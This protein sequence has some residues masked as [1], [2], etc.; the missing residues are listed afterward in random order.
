MVTRRSAF[1]PSAVYSTQV[2]TATVGLSIVP[3]QWHLLRLVRAYRTPESVAARSRLA[4]EVR[5]MRKAALPF[6]PPPALN[7]CTAYPN[8]GYTA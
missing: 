2:K 8:G 7:I 3:R 5:A 1:A 4:Q 6:L